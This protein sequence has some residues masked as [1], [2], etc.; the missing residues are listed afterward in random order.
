MSRKTSRSSVRCGAGNNPGKP[1]SL[2]GFLG[3][4][5]KWGRFYFF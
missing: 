3:K 2:S 4:I 5:K 1:A